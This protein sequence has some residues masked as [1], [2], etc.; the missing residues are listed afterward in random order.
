M[1]GMWRSLNFPIGSASEDPAAMMVNSIARKLAKYQRTRECGELRTVR[2]YG[3]NARAEVSRNESIYLRVVGFRE[4]MHDDYEPPSSNTKT[5]PSFSNVARFVEWFIVFLPRTPVH[6]VRR[7]TLSLS[8]AFAS[9]QRHPPAKC[10]QNSRNFFGVSPLAGEERETYVGLHAS[11]RNSGRRFSVRANQLSTDERE[12]EAKKK[13]HRVFSS[14]ENWLFE[15]IWER[16][17]FAFERRAAGVNG[18]RASWTKDGE[19]N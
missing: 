17:R 5:H 10:T 13:K 15:W 9:K 8:A 19:N 4:S 16:G 6:P 12:R 14:G 2:V 3:G 18:H 11:Y 7:A 1:W